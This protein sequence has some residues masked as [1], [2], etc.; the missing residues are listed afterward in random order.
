MRNNKDEF[1]AEANATIRRWQKIREKDEQDYESARQ[2]LYTFFEKALTNEKVRQKIEGE[3]R[4]VRRTGGGKL[5]LSNE[6][7]YNLVKD[8]YDPLVDGGD[9]TRS[10]K[11]IE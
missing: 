6:A 4:E 7:G 10:W 11:E 1:T 3:L 5:G 9:Y 8:D 2:G